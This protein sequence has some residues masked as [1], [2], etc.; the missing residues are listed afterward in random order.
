MASLRGGAGR[1]ARHAGPARRPDPPRHAPAFFCTMVCDV[2][3]SLG[4][5]ICDLPFCHWPIRN[6]PCGAPVLS[7]LSGPRIVLTLF[8]RIQFASFVW[9]PMPPTAFTAACTACAA[10][11]AAA[12]SSAGSPAPNI[13]L[14]VLTNSALPDVL[15]FAS[16]L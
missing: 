16:Q 2:A 15:A 8:E 10:A 12:A 3:A 9:S 11:N 6:C 5:T 1:A 13:L 7:H 14:N 4:S